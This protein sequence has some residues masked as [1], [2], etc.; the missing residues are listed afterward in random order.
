M[1]TNVN[2]GVLKTDGAMHV[3]NATKQAG[4][5]NTSSST[6]D[7][8]VVQ[9]EVNATVV[10][11]SADSTTV[12]AGPAFLMGVY[13]DVVLSA[14]ACPIKDGTSTIL[15]I[16][17]STAVG[18]FSIGNSGCAIKFN[19]SLIIDPDNAATGTVVVYWRPQ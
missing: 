9:N 4:E 16:P 14:H 18:A 2:L 10:D 19:T 5:R 7:Y 15:N 13:V 1:V 8:T 11:L 6:T 17:A 12:Y 3:T